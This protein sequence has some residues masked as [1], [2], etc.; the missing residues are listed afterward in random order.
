MYERKINGDDVVEFGVS[1]LL[2]NNNLLMYDRATETLWDQISGT[3]V[4]GE[5]TGQSLTR[6][7]FQIMTW[8]QWK[9]FFPDS[10]V[11]SRFT[12]FQ[13]EYDFWPY[14][15]Y[16][17]SGQ[18]GFG[19]NAESTQLEAKTRIMG[20]AHEEFFV[21]YLEDEIVEAGAFNDTIGDIPALIS[22]DPAT[23]VSVAAFSRLVDGQ[24]LTFYIDDNDALRD[25]ETQSTWTPTGL[26]IDGELEDVQ[27]EQLESTRL[28]WF[29]WVA[30]HPETELRQ[31]DQ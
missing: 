4:R 15:L 27:L 26:A 2:Y 29:A 31:L 7:P 9:A 25:Q 1:G 30:F 5:L 16:D 28:F 21:A 13:R 20:V 18:V 10:E 19:V 6:V 14:A 23:G 8:G 22:A 3:G 11:L 24:E 12:G 17:T